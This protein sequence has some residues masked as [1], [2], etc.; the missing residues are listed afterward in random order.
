M[1]NTTSGG[2]NDWN[3]EWQTGDVITAEKLNAITVTP[4]IVTGT[5]DGTQ[6]TLNKT[7]GEIRTAYTAGMPIFISIA[8]INGIYVEEEILQ[9]TCVQTSLEDNEVTTGRVYVYLGSRNNNVS[10]TAITDSDYPYYYY[11][12]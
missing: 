3:R 8:L 2:G 9:V 5:D 10:F 4:L 7:F 6:I 11:G 1:P 12:D